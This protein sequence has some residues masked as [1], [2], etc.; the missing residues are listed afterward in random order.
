MGLG[1]REVRASSREREAMEDVG[2]R[3]SKTKTEVGVGSR[4]RGRRGIETSLSQ[5][6]ARCRWSVAGRRLVG[7][8]RGSLIR[9][10][11]DAEGIN[12]GWGGGE[13]RRCERWPSW[14]LGRKKDGRVWD[15]VSIGWCGE[16][17]CEMFGRGWGYDVW[18][19]ETKARQ[20]SG[21]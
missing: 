15:I 11:I 4:Y 19:C 8:R 7:Q 18:V 21:N 10:L 5:E 3:R 14:S 9:M 17:V 2:G 6:R 13:S 12:W 20:V 1:R 16:C